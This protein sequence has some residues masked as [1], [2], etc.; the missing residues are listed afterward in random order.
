MALKKTIKTAFGVDVHY[1]DLFAVHETN[2][3]GNKTISMNLR[4]WPTKAL[5]RT[6]NAHMWERGY[7]FT[8]TDDENTELY[9]L[10]Y[11][12]FK[13]HVTEFAD[14]EAVYDVDTVIL[15]N[16]ELS[17][18]VGNTATITATCT[19]STAEDLTVSWKS[20]D[21]SIATVDSSGVVT[22]VSAGTAMITA[23][24]NDESTVSATCTV[25]VSVAE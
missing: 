19:P 6:P 15:D 11:K 9:A 24:S 3:S 10:L 18:A 8:L 2:S 12:L 7:D 25:T 4:G 1:E 22:A 23:T 14:A 17:L 20:S 5:C 13:A 21:E 16:T